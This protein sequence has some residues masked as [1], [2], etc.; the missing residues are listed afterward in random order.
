MTRWTAELGRVL[1][2]EE[3]HVAWFGEPVAL[4]GDLRG[5]LRDHLYLA[6]YAPGMPLTWN[7]ASLALR[8]TNTEVVAHYST[9]FGTS[10]LFA[11][12]PAVDDYQRFGVSWDC[13]QGGLEFGAS[14]IS[15]GFVAYSTSGLL[16][17]RPVPRVR[18]YLNLWPPGVVAALGCLGAGDHQGLVHSVKALRPP[19]AG[20]RADVMV[21]YLDAAG[22]ENLQALIDDLAVATDGL[23]REPTPTFT[24]PVADGMALAIGPADGDSFGM[25]RC[26]L[27]ADAII[28]NMATG[29]RRP[30]VDDLHRCFREAGTSI[31]TPHTL[32]SQRV[33]NLIH[34]RR[35]HQPAMTGLSELVAAVEYGS[36]AG[37][38]E[39]IWLSARDD[40]AAAVEASSYSGHA[41]IAL[42]LSIAAEAGHAPAQALAE[43]AA[44]AALRRPMT[45]EGNGLHFGITSVLG[46]IAMAPRLLEVADVEEGWHE[47]ADRAVAVV[48]VDAERL[49]LL[50]G[51]AG[52]VMALLPTVDL[53]DGLRLLAEAAAQRLAREIRR[54]VEVGDDRMGPGVAHG[55]SGLIA[56]A[57]AIGA[58]P[59]G[60]V[61]PPSALV[62]LADLEDQ[63]FDPRSGRW[64]RAD[65]TVDRAYWLTTHRAWCHGDPGIS[66]V[67]RHAQ[68]PVPV[69][70]GRMR[71]SDA[72]VATAVGRND[73]SLCHGRCGLWALTRHASEID[74]AAGTA[75]IEAAV[76]LSRSRSG[77]WTP[78]GL[79]DGRAGVLVAAL[80]ARGDQRA[81][82]T[83]DWA[84]GVPAPRS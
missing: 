55:L 23:R 8:G 6:Y 18:L 51:I 27:L 84:L 72:V 14:R 64:C 56:A 24:R 31:E 12:P 49:D 46:A 17:D 25:H 45:G 3:R 57:H 63:F 1:Q 81:E 58:T 39:R 2:I 77:W 70:A 29:G 38:G 21:A 11:D 40:V 73:W 62:A 65:H 20:A 61:V 26:G 15:P 41:G 36:M 59:S 82:R 5:R 60:H 68:V 47:L 50:D 53:H 78:P 16:S 74:R 43:D 67:R 22:H 54:I 7:E 13:R 75:E 19:Y 9:A 71:A 32:G 35:E 33:P 76:A 79:M 34:R 52:M 10:R 28:T 69:G 44:R 48:D 80:A 83:L 42:A 30:L 66:A 37:D 4:D